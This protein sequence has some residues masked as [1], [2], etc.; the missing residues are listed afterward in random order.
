[1]ISRPDVNFYSAYLVILPS[2]R[3]L[4]ERKV[5]IFFLDIV[6]RRAPFL[7]YLKW[8]N[9]HVACESLDTF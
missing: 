4:V 6:A 5:A 8:H 2:H 9:R 1:M 3:K 7:A